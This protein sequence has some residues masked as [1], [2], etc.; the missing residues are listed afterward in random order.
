MTDK[1]KKTALEF[2]PPTLIREARREDDEAIC[3][4]MKRT[5]MPGR[6]SLT[7]DCQP[8]FFSAIDVEGYAH[9]TAVAENNHRIVGVV[10]M[11][12]RRLYLN[13]VP[14]DFGY[15]GG[16]RIDSSLRNTTILVRL[17]NILK[18]WHQE[19]FGVRFYL[20]AIPYDNVGA[21][22]IMTSGRAGFPDCTDMG[23]LYNAAIPLFRRRLPRPQK[24]L[25]IVRGTAVG[26]DAIAEFLN[27]NGSRRQFFPV[28]TADDITADN[29][30]LRGLH[31]DD[32][33]VAVEKDR[34]RGAMACWDQLPFRRMLIADY[35]W[36]LHWSKRLSAPLAGILHTAPMPEPGEPLR[37]IVAACIAIENN[38]PKIFNLL[39][40]TILHNKYDTGKAFLVVG[41]MEKDPLLSAL[42]SRLHIS[43]RTCIYI[44]TGDGCNILTEMDERPL[45]LEL[46]AL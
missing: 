14:E 32:F 8:S 5:F 10:S 37:N 4:L 16:L 11:S 30:I 9:R 31:P 20:S 29:G 27:R 23:V 2:F 1:D 46:G 45:Y 25:R 15:I 41:L 43:T 26:A 42:K 33:Y 28:Y 13:G 19:G 34:I 44:M 7:M 36:Y 18:K 24:G 17:H 38:H 22:N 39:L 35:P 6:I 40:Q 3:A 21:R 12:K